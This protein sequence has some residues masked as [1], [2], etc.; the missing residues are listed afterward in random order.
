MFERAVA[1]LRLSFTHVAVLAKD[2]PR[3]HDDDVVLCLPSDG[4]NGPVRGA[5]RDGIL[6]GTEFTSILF[7]Y[8]ELSASRKFPR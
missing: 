3:C 2:S 1:L 7:P 4:K 8:T 6:V 5:R